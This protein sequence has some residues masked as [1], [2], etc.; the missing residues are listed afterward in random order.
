MKGRGRRMRERLE[1]SDA[2]MMQG[3]EE[4]KLWKMSYR[5]KK[6]KTFSP[7]RPHFLVNKRS[8]NVASK[9]N[10]TCWKIANNFF[11]TLSNLVIWRVAVVSCC[12]VFRGAKG[13]VE[14]LFRECPVTI[15]VLQELKVPFSFSNNE[16]NWKH[17]LAKEFTNRDTMK[18]NFDTTFHQSIKKATTGI[19]VRNN[20][21]LVIVACTYPYENV[22][23]STTVKA[24]ACLRAVIFMEELGFQEV[25]VKGD[26]LAAIEKLRALEED[27]STISILVK[28]IKFRLDKF[29]SMEFRFVPCQR[30]RVAHSLVEK[31]RRY[32]D[33][34]SEMGEIVKM[35]SSVGMERSDARLF[36]L[37]D[38]E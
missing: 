6:G 26:A 17:W 11:P 14:H 19:L 25:V 36:K 7:K 13:S 31:G 24:R 20:E 4:E 33:L 21:G 32:G 10:I 16:N 9:I 34:R 18:V 28:E 38:T 2:G 1:S 12:P 5:N 3:Y 30:N 37:V 22:A 15:Q 29:E 8:L 23:D 27:K 35:P